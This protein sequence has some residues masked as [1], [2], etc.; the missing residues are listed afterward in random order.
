[1]ELL[2]LTPFATVNTTPVLWSASTGASYAQASSALRRTPVARLLDTTFGALA[3]RLPNPIG[4]RARAAL[5]SRAAQQAAL[6]VDE[7]RIIASDAIHLR[8][9]AHDGRE[10]FERLT[11]TWNGREVGSA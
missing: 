1:E 6:Y 10:P 8:G 2:E 11:L 9:W 4:R 7:S 5:E 3:R